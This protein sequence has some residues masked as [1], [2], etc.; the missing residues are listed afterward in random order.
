VRLG[1]EHRQ[2]VVVRAQ[3]ALEQGVAVQEQV[4]RGDGGGD[5]GAR[6]EHELQ[7]RLGR[8]VLEQRCAGAGGARRAAAAPPR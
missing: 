8:D 5:P 2:A 3:A 4:L 1:L 6:A 7:C